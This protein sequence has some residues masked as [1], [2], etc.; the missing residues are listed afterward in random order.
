MYLISSSTGMRHKMD[1]DMPDNDTALRML[2]GQESPI[3][4]CG[5]RLT[6]VNFYEAD[7]TSIHPRYQCA[8]CFG[9]YEPGA[10]E[11]DRY[12]N[13]SHHPHGERP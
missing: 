11:P 3:T 4:V 6:P 9:S 13:E 5:R 12:E 10:D 8:G 1:A 7:D 2:K